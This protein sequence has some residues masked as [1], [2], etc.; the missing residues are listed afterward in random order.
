VRGVVLLSSVAFS[1]LGAD[2]R[3]VFFLPTIHHV[4]VVSQTTSADLEKLSA[5]EMAQK[6][7]EFAHGQYAQALDKSDANRSGTQM[8]TTR[9]TA[10]VQPWNP[11]GNTQVADVLRVQ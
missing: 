11:T 4:R 3:N 9:F 6:A 2:D 10:R 7:R 1:N 5:D 8:I